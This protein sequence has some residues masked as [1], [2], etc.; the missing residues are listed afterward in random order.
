M[1]TTLQQLRATA[2]DSGAGLQAEL[3]ATK[4]PQ[5]MPSSSAATAGFARLSMQEEDP[6]ATSTKESRKGR[7][8]DFTFGCVVGC[9]IFWLGSSIVSAIRGDGGGELRDGPTTPPQP[10]PPS[11][12]RQRDG[13]AYLVW[14][15]A[16]TVEFFDLPR[17]PDASMD[18]SSNGTAGY[19]QF[20]S[21]RSGVLTFISEGDLWR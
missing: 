18:G 14:R 9:V 19:Y 6:A 7:H 21:F 12:Q 13:A 5:L 20:P 3:L 17:N 4:L 2:R 11:Q 15:S 8:F 10:P 16:D 1:Y